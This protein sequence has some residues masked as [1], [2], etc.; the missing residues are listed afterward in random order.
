M[1]DNN[2]DKKKKTRIKQQAT[3]PYTPI[4]TTT[5]A[6]PPRY[7]PPT[8]TPQ[9]PSGTP[10]T[11]TTAAP[12]TTSTTPPST[13]PPA[14]KSTTTT[15]APKETTT[16]STVPSAPKGDVVGPYIGQQTASS[17]VP[18]QETSE[19]KP[20]KTT[21]K[22][23]KKTT[24]PAAPAQ[25]TLEDNVR[26]YYPQ[27]AYLLDNPDLFGADVIAVMKRAVK[28]GWTADRFKGAIQSTKYWQNTVQEA[29]NFDAMTP[30][31]QDSK[32]QD[33]IDSI[34]GMM[35]TTALDSTELY[36]FAKDM[37][38]RGISGDHLKRLTY[39]FALSKGTASDA[40][41]DVL[42]SP[43]ASKIRTIVRAYGGQISDETL[44][45]YLTEGKTAQQVQMMYKE[46]TK[47]LYPHLAAQL[48][49]DLTM[50]DITKDY[51]AIA[52]SVLEKSE[53]ELDFTKP[54]FMESVAADDGKGG[55]R[56]LSLGEWQKKLKTDDRYGYSKTNR[57]IQDARQIAFNIARAFGKVV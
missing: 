13:I 9:A 18:T 4:P 45:Q 17:S 15:T 39:G 37:T 44:K 31:D 1:A 32:T 53:S 22:T 26:Q 35:D 10:T 19:K 6:P 11:S 21:K 2:D 30:A 46:K 52:A 23:P 55:K 5:T 12:S 33:T 24:K 29:K 3:V 8:R 25:P 40:A 34:N 38:R 7:I 48:D 14:S 49:A 47:G 57:A 51:K 54:E 50:E 56:Q 42:A 43:D 41:A 28:D 16:T 20:K 36:T 27:F